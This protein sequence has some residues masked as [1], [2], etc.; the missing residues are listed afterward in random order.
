MGRFQTIAWI[1]IILLLAST[2]FAQENEELF[3]LDSILTELDIGSDMSIQKQSERSTIEYLKTDLFFYPRNN[4][5]QEIFDLKTD[6]EAK[7]GTE[8]IEYIWYYPKEN[9]YNF[10]LSATVKTSLNPV[11]ITRK[12]D[13]PIHERELE[14]EEL[15]PF[16]ISSGKVEVNEET[17]R[18]ASNIVQ[19]EDDLFIATVKIAEWIKD[20]I[21]YNL[22]T[23]TANV[24]QSSTWVL[25][26]RYGVCD[27]I[28]NVFIAMLRS[29]RIPA[30]FISGIA[31]TN[32]G[33]LND[34]GPHGWAEVYFPDFGWVAFDV[35]Y[36]QLG[37]VDTTHIKM[38]ESA[39]SDDAS[40]HYEWKAKDIDI[41]TKPLDIK[42]SITNKGTRI[43]DRVKLTSRVHKDDIGFGSYTI[44]DVTIENL[45]N[46]YIATKLTIST[47]PEVNI[48]GENSKL[49][50]LLPKEKKKINWIVRVNDNLNKKYEYLF[51]LV[52]Y[53][54]ANTST[55]RYINSKYSSP[56][57]SANEIKIFAGQ[58]QEA[59]EYQDGLQLDC[60]PESPYYFDYQQ[61]KIFCYLKN[62]GNTY[63][64][65]INVCLK[66]EC[67]KITLGITEQKKVEFN[68]KINKI[69]ENELT[70]TAKNSHISRS[71]NAFVTIY[72]KPNIII[73][74]AKHPDKLKFGE[75]YNLS[76][77]LIK[78]SFSDPINLTITLEQNKAKKHWD[79]PIMDANIDFVIELNSK[80]LKQGLNDHTIILNF[81]DLNTKEYTISKTFFVELE[82]V[83]FGQQITIWIRAL[84]KWVENIF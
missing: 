40:T 6:P 50:Y 3:L 55:K 80:N 37:Y 25:R 60:N 43:N 62:T 48:Q 21:D 26:N 65:N 53:S 28:T 63:I 71:E 1:L 67:N 32:Y 46:H 7:I 82:E 5:H 49:I 15:T 66:Q 57:Y 38:K 2:S 44:M 17:R 81:K 72:D 9:V 36:S 13:F 45:K 78:E 76:F 19:G 77:M 75:E 51:P 34:F 69:G 61:H 68:Q 12:V 58:D 11:K 59:K 73:K 47:S 56:V 83:T 14:K 20:N 39:D 84:S 42:A 70:I 10:G 30:R 74:D 4:R 64:K 54:T 29:I 18:I 27:E 79:E 22:S 35:T 41:T 23:L 8:K 16:L 33:N 52:V 31:F 24:D